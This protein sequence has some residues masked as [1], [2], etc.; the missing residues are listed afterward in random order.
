MNEETI[1]ITQ[2]EYDRLLR[3]SAFLSC[4]E[5]Y[6]VDNWDGYGL[7]QESFDE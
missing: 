3:D 5:A 1:T 6:G 7:A 4:L 2:A